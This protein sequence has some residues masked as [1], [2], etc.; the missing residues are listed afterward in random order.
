[1][2]WIY[3]LFDGLG[4]YLRHNGE[5]WLKKKILLKNEEE[6][7]GIVLL[8]TGAQVGLRMLVSRSLRRLAIRPHMRFCKWNRLSLSDLMVTLWSPHG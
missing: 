5:A 2:K 1:M 3:G 4:G 8:E 7:Q 6:E